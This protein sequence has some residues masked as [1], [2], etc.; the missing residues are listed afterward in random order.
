MNDLDVPHHANKQA[1]KQAS[2]MRHPHRS[3]KK[4]ARGRDNT[5]FLFWSPVFLAVIIFFSFAFS[6]RF[7]IF[8]RLLIPLNPT[9]LYYG[10]SMSAGRIARCCSSPWKKTKLAAI[11]MWCD[12]SSF[13]ILL[14][15]SLPLA[16][17][18]FSQGWFQERVRSRPPVK[19]HRVS[20][21]ST[22][23]SKAC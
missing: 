11:V 20:R 17:P 15:C 9:K 10:S 13:F 6:F 23:S 18:H 3:R 21:G 8:P 2:K 16:T 12:Y 4:K 19:K 1:S 5:T 14:S 7:L 22:L